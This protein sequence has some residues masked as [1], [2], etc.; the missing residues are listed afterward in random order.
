MWSVVV[1]VVVVVVVGGGGVVQDFLIGLLSNTDLPCWLKVLE[2]MKLEI[3]TQSHGCQYSCPASA[4][5][6]DFCVYIAVAPPGT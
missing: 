2:K 3:D 5:F 4:H 6:G 1:I